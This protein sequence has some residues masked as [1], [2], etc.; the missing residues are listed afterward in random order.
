MDSR[1]SKIEYDVLSDVM[2]EINGITFMLKGLI[3]SGN[4]LYDPITNTPVMIVSSPALADKLPKEILLL[5]DDDSDSLST[6][7]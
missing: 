1:L 3:D 6:S 7:S 5:A 4:Q 2:I